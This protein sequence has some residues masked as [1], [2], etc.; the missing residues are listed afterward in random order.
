MLNTNSVGSAINI[1]VVLNFQY[2]LPI[3]SENENACLR[4]DHSGK[5]HTGGKGVP[6]EMSR[7]LE[8]HIPRGFKFVGV[9]RRYKCREACSIASKSNYLVS[10][11]ARASYNS[12]DDISVR[13]ITWRVG[14]SNSRKGKKGRSRCTHDEWGVGMVE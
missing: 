6:A 5:V 10:F 14:S 8:F 13:R 3:S 9:V 1:C 4:I 12:E 7:V 2:S 11:Q